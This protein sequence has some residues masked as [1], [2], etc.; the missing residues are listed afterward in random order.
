MSATYGYMHGGYAGGPRSNVIDRVSF[1]TDGN[2][3]D[4]ADLLSAIDGTAGSSSQTYGYSAGGHAPPALNT[5]QKYS[6]TTNS[7]STD[8]G[9]LTGT[10][11]S[12]SGSQSSI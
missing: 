11:S 7:N 12:T 4:V 8:V 2:A 9:D 10:T 5:I 6:F 1:A 3:T